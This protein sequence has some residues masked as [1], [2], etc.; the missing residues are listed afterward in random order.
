MGSSASAPW[1]RPYRRQARLADAFVQTHED[2][3]ASRLADG[4]SDVGPDR[5][6]VRAVAERHE[7]ALERHAVDGAADLHETLRPEELS[8][9]VHDYIGPCSLVVAL[10]K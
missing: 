3:V 5:E 4:R 7:R 1:A 6:L 8:G 2:G 10:L 9:I